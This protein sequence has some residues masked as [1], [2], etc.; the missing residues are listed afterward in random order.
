MSCVLAT[1]SD[2][3][4]SIRKPPRNGALKIYCA[5]YVTPVA[6]PR[7]ERRLFVCSSSSTI[8]LFIDHATKSSVLPIVLGLL[9]SQVKGE[10]SSA[11]ARTQR[12]ETRWPADHAEKGSDIR[13]VESQHSGRDSRAAVN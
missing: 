10:L 11:Q 9:R 6:Y 4:P 5:R 12:N 8:R 13:D 3:T 2:I 1:R 7:E